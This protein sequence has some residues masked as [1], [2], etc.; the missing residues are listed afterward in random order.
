ME[1]TSTA[2]KQTTSTENNVDERFWP[3]V[4]SRINYPIKR[5]MNALWNTIQD[6][7]LFNLADLVFKYCIYWV[8]LHV[9]KDAVDHFITSWNHHRDLGPS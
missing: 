4:N 9:T 1:G 2:Y 3:E 5:A 6:D 7:D 8:M